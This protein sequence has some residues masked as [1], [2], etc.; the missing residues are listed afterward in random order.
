[1]A[2]EQ[3]IRTIYVTIKTMAGPQ[4]PRA[5]RFA[6]HTFADLRA[7]LRQ[8]H[9]PGDA[10]DSF[11]EVKINDDEFVCLLDNDELPSGD[12]FVN[13]HNYSAAAGKQ[14]VWALCRNFLKENL[15]S[16]LPLS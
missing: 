6:G 2:N 12:I 8:A 14:T 4:T 3:Q 7:R 16:S 9:L 10:E 1:M 13:L 5:V 11:L 15:L